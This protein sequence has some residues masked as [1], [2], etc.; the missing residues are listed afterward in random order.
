MILK[1]CRVC[2]S[3]KLKK[4]FSLGNQPL[5]NNLEDKIKISKK[6]PLEL[7]LCNYCGNCQL[8]LSISPKKLFSKY[9]YRS[10]MSKTFV[11]HF[12]K[13][14]NNY[15]KDFRLN[16]N[17]FILDIGSNDGIGLIGFKNKK[18]VNLYGIEP[19]KKLAE[20]SKKIGIKTYNTFL[21]KKLS[22]KLV[23][24]F[25]LITASNVFAHVSNINQFTKCVKNMLKFDGIF[26]VEVQYLYRM[27]KD[28]SFDN[29]YHEHVNYWSVKSLSI[30]FSKI[31]L[32]IFHVE[33]INT[34]GGS[35]RVYVKN[36]NNDKFKIN[37]SVKSFL[38]KEKK[39]KID[40]LNSFKI[41]YKK[42]LR[43]RLKIIQKLDYIKS[44]NKIIVGFGAP[45]KA[46]TLINYYKLTKYISYII[47]DNKL[48]KN[49]Y[50][51]NTNIKILDKPSKN[52]I[53]YI[54][55]F[56]WNYYDEIKK[57]NLKLASKFLNIFKP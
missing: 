31:N 12:E 39:L 49:M 36:P 3:R 46:T 56:A 25:D 54:V 5:A 35:I 33:E 44:K 40:K 20:F 10:S 51:P 14:S 32:E 52:K 30:F 28:I 45:A 17:S 27:I 1:K 48:K 9:L 23:N 22:K 42:V 7:N 8:T 29:I 53:D 50:I 34:H 21:K 6:Y 47:D 2:N 11:N 13:A 38:K 24:K 37:K 19:A 18:F 4:V 15:I 26:I 41:F 57:K 43:K 55:V 16:K